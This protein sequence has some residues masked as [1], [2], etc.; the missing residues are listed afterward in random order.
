M[1]DDRAPDVVGELVGWRAWRVIGSV[2]LPMLASV[3][4][5]NTI[6]HPDRWTIATCSDAETCRNGGDVPGQSCSCGMYA[7]SSRERLLDLGYNRGS[8]QR[9]VL[10]GEVGMTGKVIPAAWGFR[11]QRARIVRL[12]LPYEWFRFAEPLEALYRVP[13]LFANTLR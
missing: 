3:T 8:A 4:H 11:A 13:V 9:P 1:N 6:W 12:E 7:A 10:I 2:Q 5:G